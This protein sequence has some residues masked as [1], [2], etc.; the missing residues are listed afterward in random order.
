MYIRDSFDIARELCHQQQSIFVFLYVNHCP[1]HPR[2]I[3]FLILKYNCHVL[4]NLLCLGH[5]K[6]QAFYFLR[7]TLPYNLLCQYLEL[8]LDESNV[9]TAGNL[10]IFIFFH[11]SNFLQIKELFRFFLCFSLKFES[12]V[13][14]NDQTSVYLLK[15]KYL[16]VT[17][18]L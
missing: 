1:L 11:P 15:R 13:Y 17:M 9:I 6:L 4:P 7:F 8:I 3:F 5:L 12:I 18:D 16:M 10:F 14:S 2:Y